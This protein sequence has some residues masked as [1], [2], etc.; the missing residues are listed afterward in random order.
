MEAI[1]R[2]QYRPSGKLNLLRMLAVLPPNVLLAL[3]LGA[4]MGAIG[5]WYTYAVVWVPVCLSIPL[6]AC[7]YVSAKWSRLRNP[8]VALLLGSALGATMY[9]GQ[10]ATQYVFFHRAEALRQPGQMANFIADSIDQII[11]YQSAGGS[12]G[13]INPTQNWVIFAVEIGLCM[14]GAG[15]GWYV[16]SLVPYCE[17]CG[18]FMRSRV[19]ILPLGSGESLF[20]SLAGDTNEAK[21]PAVAQ[22]RLAYS[23]IQLYG[24]KCGAASFLTAMDYV[25]AS[26]TQPLEKASI[27]SQEYQ[28]V[29]EKYPQLSL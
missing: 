9:L 5:I 27:T 3:A 7:G 22:S 17:S 11:V 24:C 1:E 15:F 26:T 10:Y 25:S 28:K 18:Q 12:M 8:V 2:P 21:L 23:H 6:G 13:T 14:L 19:A 20:R 16:A 4:I 29:V